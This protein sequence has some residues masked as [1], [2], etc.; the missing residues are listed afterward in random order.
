MPVTSVYRIGGGSSI[1]TDN[2]A[3]LAA[4][5]A[6][7]GALSSTLSSAGVTLT[8]AG[9]GVSTGLNVTGSTTLSGLTV[10]AG[11][12]GIILTASGTTISGGAVILRGAA[13]TSGTM[14]INPGAGSGGRH[15][16]QSGAGG[17]NIVA[18]TGNINFENLG[19]LIFFN[20]ASSFQSSLQSGIATLSGG[21]VTV[22]VSGIAANAIVIA[23]PRGQ[24]V[25]STTALSVT[26]NAGTGFTVNGA[27]SSTA[28]F[29]WFIAK[30]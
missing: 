23:T 21:T 6:A 16:F 24:A 19:G 26:I 13:G 28:Q 22:A 20:T 5:S 18:D 7:N 29:N 1:T 17:L 10:N 14:T 11:A 15:I 27:N 25:G 3:S 8:G 4:Q 2:S 30:Y 12:G 9:L